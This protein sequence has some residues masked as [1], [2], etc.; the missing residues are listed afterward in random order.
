MNPSMPP[1]HIVAVGGLVLNADQH[2]LLLQSARGDWEFP[3]G[4]VE[5][6]E[7]L[8]QAL[9]REVLDETGFNISVAALVGVH[10]NL[11][12]PP[13]VNFD[14]ICRLLGGQARLS[15]ESLQ[16]A[17]V[18]PELALARIARP[19]IRERLRLMLAFTGRVV[20]RAYTVE[21][22]QIDANYTLHEERYV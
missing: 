16:V 1:Q 9:V 17:W 22:N 21:P 7:T 6:G 20:Y 3:G 5:E 10:S 8:P 2:V 15:A 19:V 14:F 12:L 13:S 11:R 4:Q 18:P